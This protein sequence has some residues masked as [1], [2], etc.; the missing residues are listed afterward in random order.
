[1]KV[2]DG[3]VDVE[4][5]NESIIE[6]ELETK[7]TEFPN[8]GLLIRTSGELRDFLFDLFSD[9]VILITSLIMSRFFRDAYSNT[10]TLK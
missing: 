6:K 8:P 10:M 7:C 2:K 3:A 5:I 9:R 1:M 4:D